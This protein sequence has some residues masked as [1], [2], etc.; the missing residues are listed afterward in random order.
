VRAPPS[1]TER[2][3]TR[4]SAAS[5]FGSSRKTFRRPFRH[6]PLPASFAHAW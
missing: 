4:A 6:D 5:A 2:R 3:R 1:L